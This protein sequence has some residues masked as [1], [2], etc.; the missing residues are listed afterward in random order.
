MYS[1]A[2]TSEMADR[3]FLPAVF[4]GVVAGFLGGI[5]TTVSSIESL[6]KMREIEEKSVVEL[7]VAKV[8]SKIRSAC[9]SQDLCQAF[10]PQA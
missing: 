4:F 10:W 2:T 5:L 7:N 6:F 3:D 8:H 1:R 9:G